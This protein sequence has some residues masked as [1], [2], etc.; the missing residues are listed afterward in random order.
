MTYIFLAYTYY[1]YIPQLSGK[2]KRWIYKFSALKL[3]PWKY[4]GFMVLKNVHFQNLSHKLATKRGNMYSKFDNDRLKTWTQPMNSEA[5][6]NVHQTG[7]FLTKIVSKL[8]K[9][10]V[11]KTTSFWKAV[12]LKLQHRHT[13]HHQS[14][15]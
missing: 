1:E 7:S 15:A 11:R 5:N 3:K 14:R 8:I 2:L 13:L 9:K 6:N 4:K 10:N 12:E